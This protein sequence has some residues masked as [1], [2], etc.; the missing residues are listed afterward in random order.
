MPNKFAIQGGV[1]LSGEIEIKGSKNAATKMMVASLLTQEKCTIENIPLSEDM[2]ITEELCKTIGSDIQIDGH[3]C[4]MQ[5]SSIKNHLVPELSKRNRIPILV[6]G[7]LLHR[8]GVAEIPILGGDPIGHRP[9]NFHIEALNR[10]GVKIE[11]REKSYYAEA[12]NIYGAKIDLPYP[13]VGATENIILTAVLARGETIIT[14]AAVEPE[15]YNLIDML[16]AMGAEINCNTEKRTIQIKG[17]KTLKG[18]S[19]KVIPDRNEV[20]SFA[21]AGLATRG[22]VFIRDISPELNFKCGKNNGNYLETFLEKVKNVGA[23]AEIQKNGI[24]FTGKKNFKAVNIETSPHPGFMTDWQQ[25]FCVLLTQADGESIIHETV[26]E[27]RLGYIKDLKRMGADIEISD[28]CPAGHSC[29]FQRQTFN[30]TAHVEGPTILHGKEIQIT[31]IRA[32]MAHIIAALTA[33]GE[34][35][36]S[37]IEHIDRGYEKIEERLRELGAEIKRVKF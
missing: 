28:E 12:E 13:S 31:D 36:I 17:V 20:A 33:K 5:T 37:G 23:K 1:P 9:V 22:E 21:V 30:H 27:D 19:I 24:K 16:L 32:G 11:R 15:I 3:N 14:N 25:P 34:S 8:G 6:L 29:R 2:K 4:T 26:Y 7:P 10:M 18:T 35:E